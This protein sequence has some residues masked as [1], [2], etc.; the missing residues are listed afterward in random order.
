[1]RLRA[2]LSHAPSPRG[3]A[4]TAPTQRPTRLP[5]HGTRPSPRAPAAPTAQ[6]GGRAPLGRGGQDGAGW[7]RLQAALARPALA[8]CTN[9]ARKTSRVRGPCCQERRHRGGAW[10]GVCVQIPRSEAHQDPPGSPAT[11]EQTPA[12][13]WQT[14]ALPRSLPAWLSLAVRDWKPVPGFPGGSGAAWELLWLCREW[15]AG[16]HGQHRSVPTGQ[17]PPPHVQ[18]VLPGPQ[19]GWGHGEGQT[20]HHGTS[21]QEGIL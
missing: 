11:Q 16:R 8:T 5:T 21:K 17:S 4:P 9:E 6:P 20:K 12:P 1:M 15:H 10:E 7:G 19:R 13:A 18:P 2:K 14:L 3:R